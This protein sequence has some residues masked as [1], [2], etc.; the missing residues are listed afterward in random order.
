[1]IIAHRLSTVRDADEIVVLEEGHVVQRGR[2]AEL[3]SEPGVYQ[4]LL[5]TSGGAE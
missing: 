2:H 4:R 3:I 1:V 5:T